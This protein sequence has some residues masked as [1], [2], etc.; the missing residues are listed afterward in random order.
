MSNYNKIIVNGIIKLDLSNDTVKSDAM[1][2]GYS[3]HK[4]NGDV[5]TGSLFENRPTEETIIE[6]MTDSNGENILDSSNDNLTVGMEYINKIDHKQQ[7]N[8][9]NY[10]IKELELTVEAWRD[11]VNHTI[12]DSSGNWFLYNL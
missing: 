1:L 10:R 8:E 5:I 3:A 11:F 9:L 4:S 2:Y 6:D 7:I 12:T